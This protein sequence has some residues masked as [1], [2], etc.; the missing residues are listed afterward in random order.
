VSPSTFEAGTVSGPPYFGV[1]SIGRPLRLGLSEFGYGTIQEEHGIPWFKESGTS[2]AVAN[3]PHSIEGREPRPKCGGRLFCEQSR[4]PKS[5]HPEAIPRM[6]FLSADREAVRV[7]WANV[8]FL[9]G[10]AAQG[11][12]SWA[13]KRPWRPSRFDG[14]PRCSRVR[15]R[16]TYTRTN[17]VCADPAGVR[18]TFQGIVSSQIHAPGLTC[19]CL[20]EPDPEGHHAHLMTSRARI[21]FVPAIPVCVP[22]RHYGRL[23]PIDGR[24]CS[25]VRPWGRTMCGLGAQESQMRAH[26]AHSPLYAPRKSTRGMDLNPQICAT[27]QSVHGAELA[28]SIN[29]PFWSYLLFYRRNSSPVNRCGTETS[30]VDG[31]TI[32]HA[33]RRPFACANSARGRTYAPKC[34]GREMSMCTR[35]SGSARQTCAPNARVWRSRKGALSKTTTYCLSSKTPRATAGQVGQ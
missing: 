28:E 26:D 8:T 35:I 4:C 21:S 3:P 22:G 17:F 6:E 14:R 29:S 1:L 9:C 25:C 24:P 15:T 12:P 7:V 5:A 13:H 30:F 31:K 33:A 19:T 34:A 23:S 20:P 27:L 18:A 32:R 2:L 11:P 16:K 10:E